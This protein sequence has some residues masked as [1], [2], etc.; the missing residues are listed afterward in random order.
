MKKVNKL[1]KALEEIISSAINAEIEIYT[2][3]DCDM[4][5]PLKSIYDENNLIFEVFPFFKGKT[6]AAILN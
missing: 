2:T 5:P 1:H 4:L 6:L 3:V